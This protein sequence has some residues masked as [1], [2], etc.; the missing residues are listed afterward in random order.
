MQQLAFVGPDGDTEIQPRSY[1]LIFRDPAT[2]DCYSAYDLN[3][4]AGDHRMIR[5]LLQEAINL[6]G[7]EEVARVL[8]ALPG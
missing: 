4:D 2:G 5:V 6:V 1:V 3:L 8:D 7:K